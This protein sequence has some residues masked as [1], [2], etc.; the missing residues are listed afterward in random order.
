MESNK[1]YNE[2]YNDDGKIIILY[3]TLNYKKLYEKKINK[4]T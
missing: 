3:I 1:D 2:N 4:T